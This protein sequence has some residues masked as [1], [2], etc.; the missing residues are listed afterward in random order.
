MVIFIAPA[1]IAF[2]HATYHPEPPPPP[3]PPPDEPPPLL[4][5]PLLVEPGAVDAEATMVARLPPR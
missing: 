4:P 2:L 5:P 3:P 1:G